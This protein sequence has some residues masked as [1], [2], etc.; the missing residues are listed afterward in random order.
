M[1]EKKIKWQSFPAAE[2]Q[3]RTF[4]AT[5][6]ILGLTAAVYYFYGPIYS[7]LTIVILFFSLL[8]YYTPTVYTMTS[9][10]IRIKKA[11]YTVEKT[12]KEI[13][14]FYP[15]KNGVMLSPF[16]KP[17][18]LENFRGVFVRYKNNRD[19]VL[20]FIKERMIDKKKEDKDKKDEKEN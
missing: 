20:T 8:P 19:E 15:E 4:L 7:V 3:T 11:F 9:E 18:R 17:S 5:L 6:F 16:P 1:N 13:R 14:S 10:K 2:N 12:W